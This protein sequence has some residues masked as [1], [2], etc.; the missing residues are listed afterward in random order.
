MWSAHR[1]PNARI[2]DGGIL[3]G[4]S[5]GVPLEEV[6]PIPRMLMPKDGYVVPSDTPG[7]GMEIMDEWEW[8]GFMWAAIRRLA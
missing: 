3:D 4:S 8:H 2:S 6:C 5:P 7:F 1:H